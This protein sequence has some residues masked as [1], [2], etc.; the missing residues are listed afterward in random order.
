MCERLAGQ[1]RRSH[2]GRSGARASADV[3]GGMVARATTVGSRAKEL[4][5]CFDVMTGVLVAWHD[6]QS[7]SAL[8][9][10]SELF[11]ASPLCT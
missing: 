6:A 7:E 10:L 2:C 11:F 4:V 5:S 3:N 8:N 9:L 1:T